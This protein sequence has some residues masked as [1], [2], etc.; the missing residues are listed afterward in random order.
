MPRSTRSRNIRCA[1][2]LGFLLVLAALG[3][4][5]PAVR[6]LTLGAYM[7]VRCNSAATSAPMKE[8][9][10]SSTY[11][12]DRAPVFGQR[13]IASATL[14]ETSQNGPFIVVTL[15]DPVARRFSEITGKRIGNK[16]ATIV[17]G[18]LIGSATI[19]ASVRQAWIYGLTLPEA[20]SVVDALNHGAVVQAAPPPLAPRNN[21]SEPDAQGIYLVGNG[22]SPPMV[23][24]K[25]EPEY[26]AAARAAA[27][28]GDGCVG[29]YRPG[30]WYYRGL[31]SCELCIRSIPE[32]WTPKRLSALA[33]TASNLRRKMACL[34]MAVRT[35]LTITFRL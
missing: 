5:T 1:A 35:T 31:C 16:I 14:T 11:C 24:R 13:D 28:S 25:Q 15:R 21:M 6:P 32:A 9:G 22:V 18:R 3:Q 30:G 23:I 19:Q 17:N 34:A 8:A 27:N 4:P 2:A 33:P 29:D 12:L 10:S 20:R 26:T 7:V